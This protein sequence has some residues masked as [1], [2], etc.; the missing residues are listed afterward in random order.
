VYYDLYWSKENEKERII[1]FE[2]VRTHGSV[3]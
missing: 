3:V 1:S 2:I